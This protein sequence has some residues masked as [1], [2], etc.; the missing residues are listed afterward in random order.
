MVYGKPI[1]STPCWHVEAL[2]KSVA[3][4]FSFLPK[5][6]GPTSL[7]ILGLIPSWASHIPK[8]LVSSQGR[9]GRVLCTGQAAAFPTTVV[10]PTEADALW[11]FL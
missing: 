10:W 11:Y 1:R 5:I 8:T 7:G 3:L 4:L 6:L 9:A 2:I